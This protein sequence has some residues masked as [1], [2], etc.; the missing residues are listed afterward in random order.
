M[1]VCLIRPPRVL[2]LMA[3]SQK[4]AAPF[5][6]AYLAG[7][8][9]K[10]G[11]TIKVIDGAG[12]APEQ[13]HKFIDDVLVNGISDDALIAQIPADTELIGYSCMFTGNWLFDRALIDKI[14]ERFPNA[15]I[16][17]GGEHITAVPEFCLTQ[18]RHLDICVLGEGEETILEI[19]NAMQQGGYYAHI[20]SIVYRSG[21]EFKRTGRRARIRKL[22]E[23]AEPAWEYFPV[24]NYQLVNSA[25]GVFRTRTLPILASRGCPYECTFC[26]SPQMWGTKYSLRTP[27]LVVDEMEKYMREYD[28]RNFDFFDLT[29]IVKKDWIIEFAS[30][31]IARNLQISWQ[32]PGGTRAEV[33]DEEVSAYLY[34]SG[35]TNITYAPESGSQ[36]ILDI[37][38]KRVRLPA[39]MNSIKASRKNNLSIKLNMIIGFPDE[40][41]R[42]IWK[43]LWFLIQCAWF[44]VDDM[45][46]AN[47]TPYPGSELFTRL[48]NEGKIS[49][50][51]DYFKMIIISYTYAHPKRFSEHVGIGAL[52]F[53]TIFQL[54]LFYSCSFLFRP[55]KVFKMVRNLVTRKY[56][57]RSEIL[58]AELFKKKEKIIVLD[59]AQA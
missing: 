15:T 1:K 51:D 22:D 31:I 7:T 54:L 9:K 20:E 59:T 48:I 39:M 56:E 29:A 5:G 13:Y 10:A 30:I 44:G 52:R 45:F 2:K 3:L 32:I 18:A 14:G 16:I 26:S 53:Y 35:C 24:D 42:D 43:T 40:T 46:P 21:D 25:N 33:I 12:E 37:I 49:L 6:L 58:I 23:I 47:F 4:P 17:A 34:K 55:A 19:I 38:K 8:L 11:H 57:T 50:N 27:A 41:H 36:R 28:I